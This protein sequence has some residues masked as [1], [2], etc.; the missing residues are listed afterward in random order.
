M[1][2]QSLAHYKILEKIGQG[3]MGEVYLA[4]DTKLD[5]QVALKVLPP[6]L[7]ES[8][9]RRER[10]NRE[11]KAIAALNHPNI[12]HVYS[13]EEVDGVHFITMELVR[14]QTL[15]KLI[16][17]R[18]FPLNKFFD[19]AIPMADAVAAAHEKGVIHRDLKPDNA[20]VAEDGRIKV[21]DFG[22]ARPVKGLAQEG[23]VQS[24]LPTEA[25][26]REGR[27]VGTVAYMS[28]EQAE[29]K[30]IDTRS[31]I[32]SLGIV[33]FEM[34]TGRRPF[35]GD[36]P[37]SILSSIL[38]D[39]P[40]PVTELAPGVP[41]ELAKLV[42]RCLTRDLT[43]RY[44]TA[45]DVR[46]ELE[47]I[48]QDVDSGESVTFASLGKP[49]PQ[50]RWR[51]VAAVASLAALG[52]ILLYTLISPVA[53]STTVLRL[54]NPV[55]VT[56]AVGVETQ[57]SWSPDGGRI[58]YESDRSGNRDIW[59]S[60][61]G[62]GEA[63]NRTEGDTGDDR[64]PS[65]SHD[66]RQI[67]FLS[68]RSGTWE[69]YVM[70]AVGG[71]ARRIGSI[72]SDSSFRVGSPQWSVD[73][74]EIAVAGR[75]R[76][77]NSVQ[78]FSLQAGNSECLSLP[79]HADELVLALAWLDKD[80]FAYITA[81]TWGADVGGRLWVS[82]SREAEPRPATDGLTNVRSLF[83]S[84]DGQELFFIS[85][86]D[87]WQQ[88]MAPMDFRRT[89]NIRSPWVFH[90]VPL[91]FPLTVPSSPIPWGDGSGIY[92]AFLCFPRTARHG[93]MPSD[94]RSTTRSS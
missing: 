36:S 64:L 10:F 23:A 80:R 76:E 8:E 74:A 6:E 92:G 84:A 87:L 11:A 42:K 93:R 4:E 51:V 73:D 7:A 79:D 38:K 41:R 26:T 72:P 21:L 29:G 20:M 22:L 52:V 39:I 88:S 89:T 75:D 40:L 83:W 91:P 19:I 9:E 35:E 81:G 55:Q 50:N 68:D 33:L 66:G 18:G 69:L 15:T 53:D 82:T 30:Q 32:F 31:D 13:V 28:P 71:R 34:L 58:A 94:S 25:R 85:N 63:V 57:P 61:L 49:R 62:G 1:I 65:W 24:E 5:R 67:A 60:Q 46:N 2:G 56:S 37:A 16:P 48:K 3:G 43:R 70:P 54:A 86:A 45:V 78:L 17:R 77:G 44:Q 59:V 14:G 47:E 90:S 27:I 12:V